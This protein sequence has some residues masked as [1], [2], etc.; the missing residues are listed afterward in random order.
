MNFDYSTHLHS[1][2]TYSMSFPRP[3]GDVLWHKHWT[4]ATMTAKLEMVVD[5]MQRI[6]YRLFRG[7]IYNDTII[8]DTSILIYQ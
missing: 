4:V 5:T 8:Y 2:K 7:N 1:S 3:I 6:N